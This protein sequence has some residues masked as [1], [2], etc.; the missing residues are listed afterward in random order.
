MIS[1]ASRSSRNSQFDVI[2]ELYLVEELTACICI[3]CR[4]RDG[5]TSLFGSLKQVQGE[6]SLF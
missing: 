2:C 1:R 4:V 3:R 5:V 6:I